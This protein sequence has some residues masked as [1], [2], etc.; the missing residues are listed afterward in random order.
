MSALN[1]Y[2]NQ[3]GWWVVPVRGGGI[4]RRLCMLAVDHTGNHLAEQGYP[5]TLP[6]DAQRQGSACEAR[7]P[8]T[9]LVRGSSRLPCVLVPDHD[10]PHTNAAHD[11]WHD[12][13]VWDQPHAQTGREAERH[14]PPFVSVPARTAEGADTSDDTDQVKA[15]PV[16]GCALVAGHEGK[17]MSL[18]AEEFVHEP[19]ATVDAT[20]LAE[21]LSTLLAVRG[22][23]ARMRHALR[24]AD[25]VFDALHEHLRGGGTPP[26]GWLPGRGGDGQ[27]YTTAWFDALSETLRDPNARPT[28]RATAN[29]AEVAWHALD[30]ALREGAPMPEPWDG[31]R[32]R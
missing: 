24:V 21:Q 2:P 31:R 16:T 1:R 7:R 32:G 10:G 14:A 6:A 12:T 28:L 27:R 5:F 18:D 29:A 26:R 17:H 15:C 11:R 20:V 8:V 3:C 25:R 22:N 19:Q 13:D 23:A 30:A 4:F 9:G